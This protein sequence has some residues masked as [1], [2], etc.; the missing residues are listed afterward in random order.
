[1]VTGTSTPESIQ[2]QLSE[3]VD[4]AA[5]PP[6]NWAEIKVPRLGIVAPPTVESKLPW[7]SYLSPAA[8]AVFDERF[9][10][11]L[12]WY[13]DVINKFAEKHP[14]TP[15]PKVY[16]LPGAP[17]YVYINNEAEVVRQIRDFLGIPVAG[18]G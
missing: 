7:Y 14:G 1:M 3:G 2:A 15:A 5:N 9:P 18:D 12:Q 8:Q 13:S 6:T 4:I 11:L 17:H 10:R 16:L